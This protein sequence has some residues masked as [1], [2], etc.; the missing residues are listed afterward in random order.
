MRAPGPNAFSQPKQ[1][2]GRSRFNG[3]MIAPK[4]HAL[5][6]LRRDT[7][8]RSACRSGAGEG[9]GRFV[10]RPE[11]LELATRFQRLSI[12]LRSTKV[13]RFR[14]VLPAISSARGAPRYGRSA[15]E[16]KEKLA[17]ANEGGPERNGVQKGLRISGGR[18][19]AEVSWIL[20]FGIEEDSQCSDRRF[21]LLQ[22]TEDDAVRSAVGV[23]ELPREFHSFFS[24]VYNAKIGDLTHQ[25]QFQLKLKNT[26]IIDRACVNERSN[27][28]I[29]ELLFGAATFVTPPA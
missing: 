1:H 27:L 25:L 16:A 11:V 4:A 15:G 14:P 6:V 28:L 20:L 26:F 13:E 18:R 2:R 3:R 9:L 24:F 22:F 23:S 17:V 10:S 7:R 29:F 5:R 21:S 12:R 8:K 19:S